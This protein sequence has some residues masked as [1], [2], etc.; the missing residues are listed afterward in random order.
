MDELEKYI[1]KNR[2]AFEHTEPIEGHE[3]RFMQRL[4][5]AQSNTRKN[6]AILFWRV[7]AAVIV[8]VVLAVSVLIPRFNS[9]ADVHY[10]ATTLGDVSSDMADV[11]HYYQS[12]LS[13]EYDKIDQ[14]SK[15]D[16]V[17][18]SYLDELDKLNTEY[19]RLEAT[20]YESGS[21][22]KVVLAMIENFRMRLDLMEKLEKQKNLNTK[23]DTL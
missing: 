21:H 2:D 23:N 12:R 5:A 19:Q 17:V 8:L 10:R 7:A 1:R 20:L 16:P 3:A 11:E 22:K 14:L 15:S 4:E 6:K 13:E 18:K 9:P